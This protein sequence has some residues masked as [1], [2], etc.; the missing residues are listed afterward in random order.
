MIILWEVPF[1]GAMNGV[2]SPDATAWLIQ[3]SRIRSFGVWW[4]ITSLLLLLA[5]MVLE[6]L[7]A[8]RPIK[9]CKNQMCGML[10]TAGQP[11][12]RREP[13]PSGRCGRLPKT[14][15]HQEAA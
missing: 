1:R 9:A 12:S 2:C 4:G 13:R 10:F 7:T 15:N 8:N 6:D 14:P 3:V 11:N 5:M